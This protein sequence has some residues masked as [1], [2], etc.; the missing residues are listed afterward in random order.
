MST[1]VSPRLFE[2]LAAGDAV[3]LRELLAEEVEWNVP[4]SGS[5][6]GVYR[7]LGGV[8]ELVA[9]RRELSGD[10]FRMAP[11]EVLRGDD[12]VAVIMLATVTKDGLERSWTALELYAVRGERVAECR[13]L[14]FDQAAF[15]A[16]WS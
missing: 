9:R 16:I 2:A 4:G 10:T 7:G 3:A 12:H 14:P 15:D 1:A 13:V 5:L 8:L 6:A 11:L